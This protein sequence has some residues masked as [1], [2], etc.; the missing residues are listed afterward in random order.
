VFTQ[1]RAF[2]HAAHPFVSR[3]YG[4]GLCPSAEAI[5]DT[6]VALHVNEAYSPTDLE[7]T[8]HAITRVAHW[9]GRSIQLK[10][11][12]LEHLKRPSPHL[13]GIQNV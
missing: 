11:G 4:K 1:H 8:A 9:F 2:A 10:I 12:N 6:C 3:E 13:S 7:Q 5:L